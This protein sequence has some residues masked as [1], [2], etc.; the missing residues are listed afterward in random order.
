MQKQVQKS[1]DVANKISGSYDGQVHWHDIAKGARDGGNAEWYVCSEEAHI[2]RSSYLIRRTF[3]T[4]CYYIDRRDAIYEIHVPAQNGR[5]FSVL[6]VRVYVGLGLESVRLSSLREWHE[7]AC[8]LTNIHALH[9]E[10]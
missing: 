7:R 8:V 10:I 6:C 1:L 3:R 4:S 5:F 2:T 9:G